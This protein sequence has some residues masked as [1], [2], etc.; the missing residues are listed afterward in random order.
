MPVRNLQI[1]SP[2]PLELATQ[3]PISALPTVRAVEAALHER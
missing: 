3:Y 1:A 2:V